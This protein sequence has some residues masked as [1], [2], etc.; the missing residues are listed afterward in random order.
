MSSPKPAVV[1]FGH[2]VSIDV[3][4]LEREIKAGT[5]SDRN[6]ATADRILPGMCAS[7]EARAALPEPASESGKV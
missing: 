2:K 1:R 6:R 4:R 7:I 3:I 5:L